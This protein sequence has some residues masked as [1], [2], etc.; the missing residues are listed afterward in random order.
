MPPPR[1]MSLTSTSTRPASLPHGNRRGQR[2]APVVLRDARA[3]EPA[4]PEPRAPGQAARCRQHAPRVQ[5]PPRPPEA[6][7]RHVELEAG[8]GRAGLQHTGQLDERGCRVG[9]VSQEVGEREG[10]EGIV[11]EGELLG[12]T[13][14]GAA[15]RL[16]ARPRATFSRPRRNMASVRST[17]TMLPGVRSASWRATPAVPVA[18]SRTRCGSSRDDVVDHGPPPTAVLTER[19]D[20]LEKVVAPRETGEQ[21]P[22][23]PVRIRMQLTTRCRPRGSSRGHEPTVR[24][25]SEGGACRTG[26]ST[27]SCSGRGRPA[28]WPPSSSPAGAPEWRSWTRPASHATR[29]AATSSGRGASNFSTIWPSKSPSPRR[30]TT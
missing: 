15:T 19:E 18:T 29:P 11:G 17:P 28:A 13:G 22:C 4:H 10:V 9:H 30:S 1:L 21:L 3:E 14:D 6:V 7:G 24:P 12:P 27:S 16:P 23:E 8:D 20:R 25:R 2:V 5:P 26:A